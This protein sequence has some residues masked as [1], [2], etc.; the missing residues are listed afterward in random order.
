MF[1]VEDRRVP[2][3]PG[4]TLLTGATGYVGGRLLSLLERQKIHVRCL[5]RRPEALEDRRSPTTDVV[6]GDVL[7]D[8]APQNFPERPLSGQGNT[9]YEHFQTL[10]TGNHGLDPKGIAA[11]QQSQTFQPLVL[12]ILKLLLTENNLE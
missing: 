11:R 7:Y 9:P 10:T 8:P 1:Q 2:K 12:R 6:A 3:S 4:L 5:T